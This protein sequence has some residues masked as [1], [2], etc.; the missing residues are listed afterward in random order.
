ME[1]LPGQQRIVQF[2]R[3]G[4]GGLV[5]VGPP[6]TG[7]STA[8]AAR[9]VALASEGRRPYELLVLVAQRAQAT[10]YER[11]SALSLGRQRA[12]AQKSLPTMACAGV[13]WAS[14]GRSSLSRLAWIHVEN[15]PS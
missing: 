8:L 6:G 7:K 11:A 3:R 4:G 12:G 13:W 10:R 1:L 15:R 14:F 9:L 2:A 5:A